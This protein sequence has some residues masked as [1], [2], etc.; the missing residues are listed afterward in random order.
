MREKIIDV[1]IGCIQ[2]DGLRFSVD[3]IAQKLKISK[4]TVYKYFTAKEELAVAIYGKYYTEAE[5]K[6]TALLNGDA[7]DKAEKILLLYYQSYRMAKKQIFNKFALNGAI[8]ERATAGHATVRRGLEALIP[9]ERREIVTAIIDGAF[10]KCEER[11][12]S[13]R[14]AIILL[15]RLLND[16]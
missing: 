6:L 13:V 11:R 12:L 1:S 8:R 10:E 3:E 2:K 7:E 5:E 14:K 16:H 15:A 4:K 9:V